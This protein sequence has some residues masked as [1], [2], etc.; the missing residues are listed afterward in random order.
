MKG[1]SRRKAPNSVGPAMEVASVGS[2]PSL[3]AGGNV[4][5][6]PYQVR[7]VD[8]IRDAFRRS[9]RV[10][11]V[12]PTG[13]GKT[14]VGAS[15]V[16]RVLARSQRVLEI[17]HRQELLAQFGATLE[18]EG[19]GYGV[20][21]ADEPPS[22]LWPVQLAS[23]ATLVRRD[24]PPADW[25]VIDEAHR[26]PAD[27]Y[28]RVLEAY[29]DA[30]VLGLTATPCRLDG[31][32]LREH[33][34][35]MIIGATYS[36]LLSCGAIVAPQV[37]APRR[38]PDMS[39]VKVRGGDYD[40]RGVEAE[41]R[42]PHVIGD[43]IETWSVHAGIGP[44]RTRPIPT[45][46]FATGIEHSLDLCMQ[47]RQRGALV[48][49]LDGST[50]DDERELI[51]YRFAQGQL[52]VICNVGILCEGWDCPRAKCVV[53]AAPTA[54]LMRHMQKV[55][56]ALRPFE[57]RTPLLLDHADNVSRH[58]LPHE[59]REWSLDVDVPRVHT[60]L[61]A[62]IVCGKCFG[63]V[64]KMPCPLCGYV[65]PSRPREVRKAPGM[66]EPV[67]STGDLRRDF[68]NEQLEIAR[69]KAWKPAAASAKFKERYGEWPPWAWSQ[70]A[71]ATFTADADWQSRHEKHQAEKA[72][73]NERNAE[74][75]KA[76]ESAPAADTGPESFGVDDL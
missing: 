62:T 57:G 74:R 64:A 51:L 5:L 63:Y 56:R 59:D 65:A 28:A 69:R 35:E 48:E 68:F 31:K 24:L 11:Y 4:E 71:K 6:R 32:P 19:I 17:A 43:V 26:T 22:P 7:S 9:R 39:G 66:L 72:F 12:L 76:L 14:V 47:F 36:E 46:V 23:I 33:F 37:Y 18:R 13:G 38:P 1:G 8:A 52:D 58:G 34:D 70:A 49:H 73:W 25:I 67:V 54:S 10:L 60:P 61:E 40:A 16:Q 20:I 41:M 2:N 29:P 53:D 45:V 15:I 55:G 30:R 44:E 42:R 50:P 3:S 21:R 75:V 27:S